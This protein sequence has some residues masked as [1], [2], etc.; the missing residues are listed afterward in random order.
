MDGS[1]RGRQPPLAV[2][3]DFAGSRL[4][5]QILM[6]VFE[7]VVPVIRRSLMEEPPSNETVFVE[8]QFTFPRTKGA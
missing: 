3:R 6:R 7:L 1:R 8:E 5:E 4:D 2:Q